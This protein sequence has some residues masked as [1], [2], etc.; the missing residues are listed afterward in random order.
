MNPTQLVVVLASLALVLGG[1]AQAEPRSTPAA[2]DSTS[3]TTSPST[4]PSTDPSSEPVP[5]PTFE[6]MSVARTQTLILRAQRRFAVALQARRRLDGGTYPDRAAIMAT[7]AAVP[8]H[9]SVHLA[10]FTLNRA[11]TGISY[12][13]HSLNQKSSTVVAGGSGAVAVLTERDCG[14]DSDRRIVGPGD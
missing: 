12:C 13:I 6:S 14:G 9:R 4:S 7:F 8:H 1:C 10:G 11:R 3:P 5:E 2:S